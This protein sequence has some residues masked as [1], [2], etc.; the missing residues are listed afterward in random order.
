MS[1]EIVKKYRVYN[2]RRT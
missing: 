2:C 1:I